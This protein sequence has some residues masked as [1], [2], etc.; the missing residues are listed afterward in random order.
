MSVCA[1]VCVEGVIVWA[2]K[3]VAGAALI[4]AVKCVHMRVCVIVRGCMCV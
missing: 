4:A 2:K 1:C 3:C